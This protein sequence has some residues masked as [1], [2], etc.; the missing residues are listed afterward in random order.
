LLG[1]KQIASSKGVSTVIDYF[2][3]GGVDLGAVEI[4][5]GEI[6]PMFQNHNI[7]GMNIDFFIY[8]AIRK[9]AVIQ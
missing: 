2:E 6:H 4:V 9:S 1:I 8:A 5:I 7:L 3:I